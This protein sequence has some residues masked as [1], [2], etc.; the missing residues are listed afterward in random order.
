MSRITL[1]ILFIYILIVSSL[2]QTIVPGGTIDGQVWK[3]ENSPY[4]VAGDVTVENL[5]IQAG[6]VIEFV[7]NFKFEVNGLLLVDGF[8]SDSVYFQPTPTNSAGWPGIK[9]KPSSIASSLSYCH[10]EG[11]NNE[12]INIDQSTPSIT[13]CRIVNGNGDGIFVK[14]TEI[15]LKNC[16]IQKN[17]GNGIRLDAGQISASNSI[18]SGNSQ[19]GLYSTDNTDTIELTNAV[20]A[21]NQE[22]GVNCQKGKLIIKNS[23]IYYNTDQMFWEEQIPEVSFSNIQGIE[24]DFGTENI[25][26]D[27]DFLNRTSYNIADQSPCIDAGDDSSLYNDK[28]FPPS[29]GM[30]RNDMG[31]YGGPEASGWYPPLYIQPQLVEFGRVTKGSSKTIF[32]KIHNYRNK[33]ITV[34]EIGLQDDNS[35]VFTISRE[36]FYLPVSDTLD[37]SVTFKPDSVAMFSNNLIFQT[38]Q[39]GNVSIIIK[40]EGVVPE[41]KV[42]ESK[43]DFANVS[44]G[45]F[46]TL[47]FHILNSGGDT[48]RVNLQPPAKQIFSLSKTTLKINPDLSLDTIQVSFTPDAPKSYQDSIIILSNDPEN[49]SITLPIFGRGVGPAVQVSSVNLDFG[50]VPVHSDSLQNLEVSNT[51]NENLTI[52]N[53]IISGPDSV[54]LAFEIVN[55]SI[56]FPISIPPEGSYF[57]PIRFHPTESG[58]RFGQLDIQSSD[59]FRNEISIELNG[60]GIAPEI[61]LSTTDVDFGQIPFLSDSIKILTLYNKGLLDLLVPPDS[62]IISGEDA[63]NFHLPELPAEIKILSDNSFNLEI[64]YHPTYFGPQQAS[65]RI[66]SNDPIHSDLNVA[67]TGLAFDNRPAKITYDPV[68]STAPVILGQAATLAF[69]ISSYSQ[70]DSAKLFLRQGGKSEFIATDLT[71]EADSTWS[72]LIEGQQVTERGLEYFLL[73][74]HGWTSTFYPEERENKPEYIY[75]NIPSW[76]FPY[77]T[78]KKVYQMISIP[79]TTSGQDLGDL[80]EDDLGTYDNSQYRFFDCENGVDYTEI[81]KLDKSLPPGKAIWL[82]TKSP[83]LLSVSNA[84]SVRSDQNYAIQLREG[85][86]MIST[87]FAFPILWN[88]VSQNLALRYYDGTDWL[89]ESLMEPSKGYAVYCSQDTIVEVP[90]IENPALLSFK[91]ASFLPFELDWYVQISVA[92]DHFKDQYNYVGA[93]S[94]TTPLR[95]CYDYQ[96]PLP[97]GNFVSLYIT[98]KDYGGKFSTD[99][100]QAG[101]NGYLFDLEVTSNVQGLKSIEMNAENLPSHYDWMVIS[102]ETGL[103]YRKETIQLTQSPANYTLIIGTDSFLAEFEMEYLQIPSDF[104]LYQNYPN[105]F[106]PITSICYQ[107]PQQS[108]VTIEIFNILGQRI[109]TLQQNEIKEAGYYQISWDGTG[110]T[111]EKV[112]SGIYILQLRTNNYHQSIK[113]MIQR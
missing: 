77:N 89:F 101:E 56:N 80:F 110:D 105:P 39:H 78:Q 59:P 28:F 51:G 36:N 95:D 55:V 49:K 92:A 35:D 91:K 29:Q 58:D 45:K 19:A 3:P 8:Y 11:A 94:F 60:T 25:N 10:I 111:G 17:A 14:N 62:L 37:F 20:V 97:I 41:I 33:G 34:P 99:F 26:L 100:R 48:L 23:I 4:R 102:Q 71:N 31:A 13:N 113:M 72:A 46:T 79:M 68:H 61:S 16:I 81:L 74:Y 83:K 98:S 70:I 76:Q 109:K 75:V 64:Q 82:I 42:L 86:N 69:T 9:F 53:A 27:P 85:W 67:L 66:H 30:L 87:P 104:R 18:F 47:D 73:A 15:E 63:E 107:L 22:I 43:L 112:A 103:N 96:E 1:A 106:N 32:L 12:A 6:V 88:N 38:E 84:Q 21:D 108:E 54:E 52:S 50:I 5:I 93:S 24:S 7:G 57:L 90:P 40:G 65:L 2:S 44:L